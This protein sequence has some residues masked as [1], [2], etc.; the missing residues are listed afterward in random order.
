MQN[1]SNDFYNTPTQCILFDWV[2]CSFSL[3]FYK[4]FCLCTATNCFPLYVTNNERVT[5]QQNCWCLNTLWQSSLFSYW[6]LRNFILVTLFCILKFHPYICK[7]SIALFVV[8]MDLIV[9]VF[10]ELVK[11]ITKKIGFV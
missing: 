5:Q 9:Y 10:G 4:I 1:S 8:F 3:T 11:K 2:F 6:W 7:A